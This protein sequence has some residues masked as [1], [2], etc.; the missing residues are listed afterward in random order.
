[1]IFLT[2]GTGLVGAHVLLKLM[3]NGQS[4]R[5]LKRTQSKLSVVNRIFSYY[6]EEGL[7][8]TI[9]W[10]DGDILDILS[11]R[12]VMKGCKK[13]I[14]CAAIVSFDKSD[15]NQMMKNNIQGTANIVNTSLEVNILKLI[16]V[17]SIAT[18]CS[19][20]SPL[21]KTEESYFET[22]KSNTQYA[23]SKY[24]AEQEVWRGF[25]RGCRPLLLILL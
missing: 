5:A 9:D 15:Y 2:G 6:N 13:V 16:H 17:S 8:K 1:M 20:T 23:L 18:L 19:K 11:L 12:D 14:H 24:L 10:V 3:Q 25:K 21:E 7:F 4:V 22:S